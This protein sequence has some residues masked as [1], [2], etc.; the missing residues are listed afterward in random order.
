MKVKESKFMLTTNDMMASGTKATN[1]AKEL[2]VSLMAMF[3]KG[4]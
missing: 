2:S 4:S 3:I 1:M